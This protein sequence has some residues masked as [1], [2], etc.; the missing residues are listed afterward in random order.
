MKKAAPVSP[1]RPRRARAVQKPRL[2][3]GQD[4]EQANDPL[5]VSALARGLAIL[6]CCGDAPADLSVSEIAQTLG[7]VQSTAWRYCYTLL[8]L[9]YLVRVGKDRMR[10]GLPLLGMGYATLSRQ[11]MAELAR[12]DMEEIARRF[13]GAV[14]L[15]AREGFQILYLQRVEGGP[16]T[17]PGLRAGSRVTLLASAMGWAYV[18][19][20]PPQERKQFLAAASQHS[21]ELYARIQSRLEKAI[22]DFARHGFIVNSGL[23]HPELSAIA[24]PVGL[25]GEAPKAALSFGGPKD[26]F[27]IRRLEREVAPHLRS[28]AKMLSIA[29]S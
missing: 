27:P 23:I 25:P 6:R 2:P 10:P 24:F 14:S 19:A 4:K 8:K 26:D 7:L 18:A 1:A 16:V 28:L 9:G 11:P 12:P 17:Y 13:P 22:R 29:Q 15:G 3:P 20:L 5:F 21:P